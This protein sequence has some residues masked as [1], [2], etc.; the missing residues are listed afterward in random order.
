MLACRENLQEA[1][2][3]AHQDRGELMNWNDEKSLN[4]INIVIF[5]FLVGLGIVLIAK[6]SIAFG[7]MS[8]ASAAIVA[9]KYDQVR[10][11]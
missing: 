9:W 1:A 7:I 6:N 5:I 11:K 10:R 3:L 4:W 2:I 8:F